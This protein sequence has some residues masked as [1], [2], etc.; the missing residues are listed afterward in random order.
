MLVCGRSQALPKLFFSY[1]SLSKSLTID[2]IS[3]T[4]TPSFFSTFPS[5][6]CPYISFAFLY[7]ALL[8][9]KGHIFV[10]IDSGNCHK[11]A[12][13]LH[14]M[15]IIMVLMI[16]VEGFPIIMLI[17]VVPFFMILYPFFFVYF[18]YYHNP[19]Q[20]R[21]ATQKSIE[22]AIPT[23]VFHKQKEP[24]R[25]GEG[26]GEEE[27]GKDYVINIEESTPM[28]ST[29]SNSITSEDDGSRVEA[30]GCA[31]CLSQ[32]EEGDVLRVLPCKGKHSFHKE[33]VDD[34]LHVNATCPTCRSQ[35]YAREMLIL[36]IMMMMRS[37]K[38]RRRRTT[39]TWRNFIYPFTSFLTLHFFL[40]CLLGIHFQYR[41]SHS[42]YIYI[43][44]FVKQG[45]PQRQLI[46]VNDLALVCHIWRVRIVE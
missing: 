32:Y 28:T 27:G 24:S 36:K 1:L 8:N 12:K 38:R 17:A 45:R 22:E 35:V 23:I 31:I 39:C 11:E 9:P 13:I 37:R 2:R 19:L 3:T 18:A 4:T 21:G 29:C 25:E 14:V 42:L 26:E 41:F 20:G 16:Y 43:F 40:L 46:S 33:C 5:H 34:W 15:S 44:R 6:A 10:F 30:T 7:V